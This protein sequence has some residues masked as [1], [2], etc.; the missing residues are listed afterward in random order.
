MLAGVPIATG[1][2]RATAASAY[3]RPLLLRHRGAPSVLDPA[4]ILSYTAA[5]AVAAAIPGPGITALVA[6]AAG[7][8]PAPAFAMLGGL[9]VGDQLYLA[10]A[11]FG[12]TLVSSLFSSVFVVIRWFS[13]LYLLWLAWCFWTAGHGE[14]ASV[15]AGGRRDLGSSALAGLL[16]TLGNPKTIAFYLAVLPVVIDLEDVGVVVWA[17]VLAPLTAAVLVVVLSA[18]ILAAARVR[19]LLAGAAARRR[20]HRG[21]AL[22]MMGAAGTMFAR[23]L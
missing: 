13:I 23:E 7:S 15:A 10:F 17:T 21:A 9:L 6:R 19:E 18:Y 8:G 4:Q 22:A 2:G 3:T 14:R 11:V 12:L 1:A 20:L 5:I 16:L